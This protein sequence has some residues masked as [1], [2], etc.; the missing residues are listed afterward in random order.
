MTKKEVQML[1]QLREYARQ[2]YEDVPGKHN[3]LSQML[4]RDAA[5]A[6]S[7]IVKSLDEL[8]NDHV[9]VGD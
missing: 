8:L 4:A 9:Q 7:S 5:Y 3:P 2:A 1:V 6:L